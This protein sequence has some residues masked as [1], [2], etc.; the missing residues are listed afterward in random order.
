M[1]KRSPRHAVVHKENCVACGTCVDIC[2][3]GAMSIHAGI[4]AEVNE[5]LCVGCGMC[6]RECPASA[7]QIGVR[8]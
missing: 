2:P 7:I 1:V 3:R 5:D 4:F 8:P 6:A